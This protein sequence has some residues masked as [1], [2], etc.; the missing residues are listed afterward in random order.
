MPFADYPPILRPG[1]CGLFEG[2][3]AA[4]AAIR[5]QHEAAAGVKPPF[6]CQSVKSLLS[7]ALLPLPACGR[8]R[9][10]LASRD[11]GRIPLTRIFLL[12]VNPT[13]PARGA[14]LKSNGPCTPAAPL[15]PRSWILSGFD[16]VGAPRRQARSVPWSK[17]NCRTIAVPITRRQRSVPLP[18]P[19]PW[20]GM[21]LSDGPILRTLLLLALPTS[22]RSVRHLAW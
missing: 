17:P 1:L 4:A 22:S 5:R 21:R 8:G 6:L 20:R 15:A 7:P 3:A 19:K 18:P 9:R 12:R 2:L 10:T 11:S 14:R 13:L 16:G